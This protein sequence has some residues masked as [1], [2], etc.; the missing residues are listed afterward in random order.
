M[1]FDVNLLPSLAPSIEGMVGACFESRDILLKIYPYYLPALG[2]Y[3]EVRFG[4]LD[5]F[6]IRNLAEFTE[7][8]LKAHDHGITV[9][10]EF[11]LIHTLAYPS[12]ARPVDPLGE[13]F[14]AME[15][16]KDHRGCLETLKLFFPGLKTILLVCDEKRI[17]FSQGLDTFVP[18][19][20]NMKTTTSEQDDLLDDAEAVQDLLETLF[21]DEDSKHNVPQVII[22]ASGWPPVQEPE[23]EFESDSEDE[24]EDDS[25]GEISDEDYDGDDER[26][27]NE[28]LEQQAQEIREGTDEIDG[29]NQGTADTEVEDDNEQSGVGSVNMNEEHSQLRNFNCQHLEHGA[30]DEVSQANRVSL[31]EHDGNQGSSALDIE[32]NYSDSSGWDADVED[33]KDSELTD[34]I[35]EGSE[36]EMLGDQDNTQEEGDFYDQ[37]SLSSD[38]NRNEDDGLSNEENMKPHLG[39]DIVHWEP[40][41]FEIYVDE[42]DRESN[43][44]SPSDENLD[45]EQGISDQGMRR[46]MRNNLTSAGGRV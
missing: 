41:N 14:R 8:L 35:W 25:G 2:R 34:S 21:D 27:K 31:G 44:E 40:E 37:G 43:Q 16:M 7:E 45:E 33:W 13:A 15:A 30:S 4:K 36:H 3:K 22:V 39:E 11:G 12:S 24:D 17:A 19:P 23:S 1:C 29:I 5:A 28:S 6:Y 18:G 20:F 46:W 42:E 10:P 26:S 38:M 32:D 9:P